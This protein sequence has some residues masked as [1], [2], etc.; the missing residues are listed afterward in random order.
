MPDDEERKARPGD[1]TMSQIV[2]VVK[3]LAEYSPVIKCVFCSNIYGH[4]NECPV[5]L[6]RTV[7]SGFAVRGLK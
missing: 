3:A 7:Y 1:I 2:L 5:L 6:A 4:S